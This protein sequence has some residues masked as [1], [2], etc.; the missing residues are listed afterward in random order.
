[1]IGEHDGKL[2]RVLHHYIDEARAR[3]DTSDVTAVAIDETAARRGHDYISL[4][5]DI[6]QAKVIFATEGK[7]AA[8]VTACNRGKTGGTP[9]SV[10]S[11]QAG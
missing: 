3:L 4:F 2:W 8:T 7:G 1:M 5:V 6:D 9:G 10:G 11:R